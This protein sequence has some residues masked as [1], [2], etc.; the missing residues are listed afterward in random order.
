MLKHRTLTLERV[1]QFGK[2]LQEVI[3]T[4]LEPL[5]ATY[6]KSDEPVPFQEAKRRRFTKIA[7]G[8][9]W[10]HD[11]ECAWFRLEGKL[12]KRHA[13]QSVVA[14]IDLGGEACVFDGRGNPV[15]GLTP[16]FDDRHGGVIGPKR[17]VRITG[18]ARGSETVS[19]M[20]DAGANHLQGRQRRCAFRQADI[21]IFHPDRFKLFHEFRFLEYLML[22][23]PETSRHGQLIMRCLNDVCNLVAGFTSEEIKAARAHLAPELSRPAN[24]SALEVSAIGHA[25]MDVAWLWPLRETVRK[26]ARTFSTALRMMEEYPDYRFGASQPHL[27]Q[28]TRD[29][30]PALYKEIKAAVKAGR[31]EVQGGM[32]VE[33]DCNIPSGESLVRQVL[34]GKRFFRAEFGVDVDHLWL[35]DVFG[36]S[37]ALPQILHRSGIK[38]FTTHKLNWNQFNRFPHHTM[39]W[40]GIDGT[41][42]FAH[43][44]TG[45]DYNVPATPGSF[46]NFERENRDGDRTGH[47]LCLYGIGDGGGGPGRTHIEWTSLAANLEDLPR[48]RMEKAADF[49]PKAEAASRDLMT[50]V[51]ELYFEYH[52]G[53]YTSQALVKKMNRRLELLVRDVEILYA[54]LPMKDYPAK[55]LDR[56]WKV[57]LLNQFHDIIPGSSINRVYREAHA[58]Y[59]AAY[60]E[61]TALR[62]VAQNRHAASINTSQMN[63]P[64]VIQNTLSWPRETC[65]LLPGESRTLWTD[66]EGNALVSQR[67]R[68]GVLVE[69]EV[70]GLGHNVI[71]VGMGRQGPR[72]PALPASERRLENQLI[73]IDFAASGEIRRIYD[74]EMR[75]EILAS[76]TRGNVFKLYE[77]Q[78]LAY[79]AWDID[80]FYLE[81]APTHPALVES[82]LVT[83]G[84]LI[85]TLRQTWQGEGFSIIQHISVRAHSRIIEFETEVDW[86]PDQKMLRVDFP[87]NIRADHANYEI[88]FGHISRPTHMNTSWDMARFEVVAHKWADLSQ[89]NYGVALLNDCKYGHR[90]HGNTISLNLLRSPRSPDPEADRHKHSFRYALY[91]HPGNLVE[92]GVVQRAW[93]FNV[94]ALVTSTR[95]RQGVQAASD[96]FV[97]CDA[98]NVIVDTVKKAEDGNDIIVRLYEAWGIDAPVTLSLNRRVAEVA[99]VD[100]MEENPVPIK[101]SGDRIR[102]QVSPFEIR[103]LRVRSSLPPGLGNPADEDD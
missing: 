81:K 68:G 86:Q 65:V 37:A 49:F 16:K 91:P 26:C 18:A 59:N 56:I 53:T 66:A 64:Q 12:S 97:S 94:P 74:K 45:N 35:P 90:I 38:Y 34:H 96:S 33:S 55:A 70:P 4:D 103:T 89:S 84:P 75:R 102:L 100:L 6:F 32:W 72:L 88:Q 13:G 85:T 10:G 43:F 3:Y 14:L 19:L 71:E 20:L 50:W 9:E 30:Y 44:M 23:L 15:Q 92:A 93:E 8:T 42:I 29:N 36:Y 1:N 17:E 63:D 48:V 21:A 78:P 99:E 39:Y 47:A 69:V 60:E 52:R 7:V 41:R 25:H 73:R 24:H 31:W 95:P 101:L 57:I 62:D 5:A 79:E 77:D 58:Q 28:M 76:G 82:I 2:R 11:F 80:A 27:Y 46:M 54:Q 67:V 40:E 61:L 83:E 22:E 87:V 98:E 51:G